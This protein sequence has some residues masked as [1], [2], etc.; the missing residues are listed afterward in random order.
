MIGPNSLLF[1]FF[2]VPLNSSEPHK[3]STH[4]YFSVCIFAHPCTCAE[5]QEDGT[6]G[7]LKNIL[8]IDAEFQVEIYLSAV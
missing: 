7:N 4:D 3:W 6:K 1:Y 5:D 8:N 2:P